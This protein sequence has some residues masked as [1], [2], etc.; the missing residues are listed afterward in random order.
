[1]TT[2]RMD[3][4]TKEKLQE[5]QNKSGVS[6]S[7]IIRKLIAGEHVIQADV[8]VEVLTMRDKLTYLARICT[9]P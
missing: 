4:E 6:Q 1:M 3:T 2:F 8:R 9:T 7:Q 5:L